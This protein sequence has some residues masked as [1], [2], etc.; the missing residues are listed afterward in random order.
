MRWQAVPDER[1][2]PR[3][4]RR[5]HRSAAVKCV[6]ATGARLVHQRS[7]L[8]HEDTQRGAIA[9][10]HADAG[11]RSHQATIVRRQRFNG[12]VV[13]EHHA[14][15]LAVDDIGDLGG[16]RH[17]AIAIA[18]DDLARPGASGVADATVYQRS[19]YARLGSA[20]RGQAGDSSTTHQ[21][22][23][24]ECGHRRKHINAGRGNFHVRVLLREARHQIRTVY[25]ADRHHRRIA[26]GI[27][28]SGITGVA[29]SGY[30]E[31]P[32][33]GGSG[34]RRFLCG[35]RRTATQAHAH[36][37]PLALRRSGCSAVV[38]SC[39]EVR[40][41]GPATSRAVEHLLNMNGKVAVAVDADYTLGVI[42]RGD[43]A[44]DVRAMSAAVFVPVTAASVHGAG[45]IRAGQVDVQT[46]VARI[47]DADHDVARGGRGLEQGVVRL[48]PG[49]AP[50]GALRQ[51]VAT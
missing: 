26:C 44:S 25:R 50:R 28:D 31:V 41:V 12:Q 47:D 34:E 14:H 15:T 1:C 23:L 48:H 8:R 39:S 35:G 38:D 2:H 21:H 33:S 3:H 36:H 6:T 17:H 32:G 43:G 49:N 40:S 9:F 4:V 13:D 20:Y 37:R 22:V 46:L 29:G 45:D 5:R 30:H 51:G 27:A 16:E 42:E 10:G 18:D 24:A 7:R 11:N 19:G